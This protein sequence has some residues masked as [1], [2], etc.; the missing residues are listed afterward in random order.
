MKKIART[1][2]TLMVA[3]ALAGFVT[4]FAAAS[5]QEPG[6]QGSGQQPQPRE[7]TL[8][9]TLMSVDPDAMTFVVQDASGNQITFHYDDQTQVAGSDE[10]VE[11]LASQSGT[12]V[13]VT[14]HE[15]DSARM[16]T[17]IE[18]NKTTMQ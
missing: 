7:Q 4:T 13:T 8:S 5:P 1:F 15:E 11:G 14:Y 17:K 6:E 16:A 10:T 18:I 3:L 9:G 12:Q 2:I